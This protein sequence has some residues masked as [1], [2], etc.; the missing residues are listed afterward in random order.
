MDIRFTAIL[1]SKYSS[2][3]TR[4]VEALNA[5]PLDL[6]HQLKPSLLCIDSE[7][8]R[9]AVKNSTLVQVSVVPCIIVAYNDGGVE[10]FE[11][12]TAFKW[13]EAATTS[14]P[15]EPESSSRAAEDIERMA[16]RLAEMERLLERAQAEPALEIPKVIRKN[17]MPSTA[18]GRTSLESLPD[19]EDVED[20][21]F[22][23]EDPVMEGAKNALQQKQD[24]LHMTAAD[25]QKERE[26]MEDAITRKRR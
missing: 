12:E 25:L 17:P 14:K 13:F 18:G 2:A 9:L 19:L 8:I 7:K 1:Y 23:E 26:M 16:A 24:S 4:L 10:K 20:D 3:S 6:Q 11:G 22:I 5:M 21:E 15:E